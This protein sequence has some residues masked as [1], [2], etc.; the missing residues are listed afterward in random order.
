M[1]KMLLKVVLRFQLQCSERKSCSHQPIEAGFWFFLLKSET[2]GPSGLPMFELVPKFSSTNKLVLLFERNGASAST[3]VLL[4]LT[5]F[6]EE[7]FTSDP[8]LSSFAFTSCSKVE[9]TSKAFCT[10]EAAKTLS[11]RF[12]QGSIDLYLQEVTPGASALETVCRVCTSEPTDVRFLLI[13]EVREVR[14]KILPNA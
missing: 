9:Q 2:L 10:A 4:H 14:Y 8:S 1:F 13:V 3:L 5:A 6:P 12:S 11:L 7:C